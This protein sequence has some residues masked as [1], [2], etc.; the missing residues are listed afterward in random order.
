MKRTVLALS[1]VFAGAAAIAQPAAPAP[2][3]SERSAATDKFAE[4]IQKMQDMHKRMQVA[5]TPAERQALMDEHMK[6]MQ[7]GMDMMSQRGGGQGMGMGMGSMGS[8]SGG[9]GSGGMMDTE[10]RMTMMEQMMQMMV[11]REAAKSSP[12]K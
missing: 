11:D 5:K 2:A 9:V 12:A 7:S 1:L 6:L 8:A 10:R 3:A 4:Q